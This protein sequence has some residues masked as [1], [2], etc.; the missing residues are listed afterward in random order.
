MAGGKAMIVAGIGCRRGATAAAI[1]QSIEEALS[2][3]GLERSQLRALATAAAKCDERGLR[4]AAARLSLPLI[5]L[6]ELDLIRA[7][8]GALTRSQLVLDLKG[9]P[10][11]AE[12]AAL[13]AA[14]R[15]ARLLAPR[16]S[17]KEASCAIAVGE[18]E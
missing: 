4:E 18:S 9:V 11:I 8:P 12:T 16:V 10:S 6:A 14:G 2:E 15:N 13:A 17:N 7:A 3:C 1:E 5:P